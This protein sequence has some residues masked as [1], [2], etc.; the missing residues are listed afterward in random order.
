MRSRTR[1]AL[2]TAIRTRTGS[3]P[4]DRTFPGADLENDHVYVDRVTGSGELPLI[5]GGARQER[6]DDFTILFA[7]QAARPGRDPEAA[8]LVCEGLMDA[9]LDAVA[10]AQLPGGALADVAGLEDLTIGM[11]NG[12]DSEALE[13]EG[14]IAYGEIEIVCTA[15]IL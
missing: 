4:V 7:F 6:Q 9:A 1:T 2:G 13:H 8:E 15:R 10:E 12:P 3:V 14:F 11:V 5:E